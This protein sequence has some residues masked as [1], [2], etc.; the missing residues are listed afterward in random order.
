MIRNIYPRIYSDSD[1]YG[2]YLFLYQSGR[3]ML[4]YPNGFEEN[5]DER[6]NLTE[7]MFG[8]IVP[9]DKFLDIKRDK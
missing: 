7:A 2:G 9:G 6:G 8:I 3:C 4:R 1:V 5:F